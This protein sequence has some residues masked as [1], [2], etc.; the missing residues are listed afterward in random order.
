MGDLEWATSYYKRA[1]AI[2]RKIDD[3]YMQAIIL[4][5]LG[6]VSLKRGDLQQADKYSREARDISVTI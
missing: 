1:I 2:A 3:K 6:N 4:G 5:D